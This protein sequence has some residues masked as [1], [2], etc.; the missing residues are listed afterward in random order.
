MSYVDSYHETLYHNE[1]T[2]RERLE[3]TYAQNELSYFMFTCEPELTHRMIDAIIYSQPDK[4]ELID[5]FI[6]KYKKDMRDFVNLYMEE[7]PDDRKNYY[8]KDYD[9][10]D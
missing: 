4:D 9:W 5:E 7:I 2:C 3:S 8:Y 6:T 10:G 1:T